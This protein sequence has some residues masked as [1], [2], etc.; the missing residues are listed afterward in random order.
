MAKFWIRRKPDGKY[1]IRGQIWN[2]KQLVKQIVLVAPEEQ[3]VSA[4]M[5]EVVETLRPMR[6]VAFVARDRAG[7]PGGGR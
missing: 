4:T 2:G 1:V 7:K 5:K 3:D 6:E